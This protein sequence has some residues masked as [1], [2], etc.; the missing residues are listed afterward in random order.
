M[1][2]VRSTIDHYV[3]HNATDVVFP[4]YKTCG[5]L[6]EKLNDLT[7]YAFQ[8]LE[9][10]FHNGPGLNYYVYLWADEHCLI[11]PSGFTSPVVQEVEHDVITFLNVTADQACSFNFSVRAEN[12]HGLTQETPR[13]FVVT[14]V[15]S[16]EYHLILIKNWFNFYEEKSKW[17]FVRLCQAFPIEV[18]T[19]DA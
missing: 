5:L 2:D 12:I 11:K 14:A 3:P 7:F 18:K 16:R 4:Q 15:N 19:A 10:M 6:W 1:G 8:P 13:S 9:S 17:Y